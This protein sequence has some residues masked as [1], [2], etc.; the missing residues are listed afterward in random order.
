MTTRRVV[1][2]LEKWGGHPHYRG[3][4]YH[5]GDDE[6][7]SWL[8]GWAGREVYRGAELAFVTEV[9]SLTVITPRAWWT[10]H[11]W[12]GHP[13]VELYVNIDTPAEWDGDQVVAVDLDL[14]VIRYNDGRVTIVDED[15]FALHQ[16]QLGYPRDLIA[17]ARTAADHAY[18]LLLRNEPPFDGEAARRWAMRARE[19]TLGPGA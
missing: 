11:W 4:M 3:P 15:E 12:L 7:G 5:L 1:Y 16:V 8:W 10:A 2:A 18:D 9:D 14:D 17:A 6:H 13:D 19:M